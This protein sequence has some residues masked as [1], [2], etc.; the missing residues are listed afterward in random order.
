[1]GRVDDDDI[2][3]VRGAPAAR[4]PTPPPPDE[5]LLDWGTKLALA[6]FVLALG[7]AVAAIVVSLVI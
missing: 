6:A 1:M 3:E 4:R 5:P 7:I 2:V